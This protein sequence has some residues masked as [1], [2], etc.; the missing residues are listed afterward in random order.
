MKIELAGIVDVHSVVHMCDLAT[1]CL[2]L[3]LALSLTMFYNK[4]FIETKQEVMKKKK[5]KYL[6]ITC[7]VEEKNMW[8]MFLYHRNKIIMKDSREKRGC[9]VHE[10]K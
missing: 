1:E 8:N 4:L 5:V 10:N 6:Y 9:T 3:I 7:K 2:G